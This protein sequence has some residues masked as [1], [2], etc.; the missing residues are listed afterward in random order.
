MKNLFFTIS[1]FCL[2]S[3]L[4]SGC[5]SFTSYD[6]LERLSF[7]DLEGY[8]YQNKDYKPQNDTTRFMYFTE[9]ES[10]E[11]AFGSIKDDI[12][13]S[14]QIVVAVVKYEKKPTQIVTEHITYEQKEIIWLYED[15]DITTKKISPFVGIVLIDKKSFNQVVFI[16][17][18]KTVYIITTPEA[19]ERA[20]KKLEETFNRKEQEK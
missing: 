14:K 19:Q 2:V 20:K 4:F 18:G 6:S 11:K 13:F 9:K 8:E 1:I 3:F 16:E 5:V 7:A 12:D 15:I 10:F 17:N